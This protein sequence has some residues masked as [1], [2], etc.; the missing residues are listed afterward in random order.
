MNKNLLMI[1]IAGVDIWAILFVVH[2]KPNSAWE[3]SLATANHESTDPTTT[4][5]LSPIEVRVTREKVEL[6]PHHEATDLTTVLKVLEQR[7]QSG[8]YL[9]IRLLCGDGL[10]IRDWGPT[11]AA[12]AEIAD[13]LSIGPDPVK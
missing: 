7:R 10:A 12:L 3:V 2:L 1:L 4:A 8:E 13:E 11:A 9:D 6:W 5:T